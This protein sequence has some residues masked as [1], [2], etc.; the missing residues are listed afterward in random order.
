MA[1]VIACTLA[2]GGCA[3][4]RGPRIDPTGER[5]FTA[6]DPG[7]GPFKPV[8]GSPK[9]WDTVEL[10][11]VPRSTIAPVGSEVVL[12]AGV[13][14]PDGYLRTNERIEW[15]ISPG[16]VGE[17]VDYDRG[18]F[19]DIFH[20][21]WPRPHK[22]SGTFVVGSTSRRFLRLTRGTPTPNDD[23]T[24]LRGQTWVSVTS[25]VEGTSYITAYSPDVF[26]WEQRK[27]TAIV[28][29]VDAQWRL[30]PPAINPAGS[31]HVFTTM[32]MRQSDQAPCAGWRVQYSIVDGPPAGFAPSGAASV[33]VETNAQGQASAEIFQ[34]QPASGTN[35]IAI[36]IIRPAPAGGAAGTRLVVGGGFTSKTWTAPGLA[37]RKS[38]PAT[39]AVGTTLAYRIEVS[40]PGDM[41]NDGVTLTDEV[42]DET[43][44][45]SSNPPGQLTGRRVQWQMG[46]LGPG[47]RRVIE[48]LL[49]AER[50]GTITT[51]AEAAAANGLRAKD[52]A[53]TTISLAVPP[54]V[55]PGGTCVGPAGAAPPLEVRISGPDRAYVG[56]VVRF[57]IQITN[58][59]ATTATGIVVK[60]R[61][62]P[63]LAHE[64]LRSPIKK[65]LNEDLPAGQSREVFVEFRAVLPGRQ[66]QTVEITG[67]GGNV[68]RAEHCV[69]VMERPGAA[70]PA[71]PSPAPTP[72]STTPGTTV[73]TP[74]PGATPT[75]APT[76]RISVKLTGP[77]SA[78]TG[79][80]VDF[81]IEL[82]NDGTQPLT[83]LK[84]VADFDP[85]LEPKGASEAVAGYEGDAVYW[86]LASLSAAQKKTIQ[87][88]CACLKE[89]AKACIRV[90]VT[91]AGAKPAQEERC[92]PI[93]A[94]AAAAPTTGLSVTISALHEPVAVGKELTYVVQVT[95]GGKTE[96]SQVELQVLLPDEM[97]PALLGM[98]GPTPVN[99]QGKTVKFQPVERLRP[100]E[101]LA[102][103][104]RV[105]AKTAGEVRVKAELTSRNQRQPVLAEARTTIVPGR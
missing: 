51:C 75:P 77:S 103:R 14:G 55:A 12:L 4:W 92:L 2:A 53:T 86:T 64:T 65:A 76:G 26:G 33:E 58:R 41:P 68:A 23:V 24:V 105:Q 61:F 59:G 48:V 22:P 38:G 98:H 84:V 8:P 100:G 1:I 39:G 35:R 43:S 62:D 36:Q 104:V 97:I 85:A 57:Q 82:A 96:E 18:T 44:Y 17:F 88:R 87:V 81:F 102:Y 31:R 90:K 101:T 80:E 89:A 83:N 78:S 94:P 72:P 3:E 6:S 21:T 28:H 25:P 32:V 10:L 95:N 66:C 69:T 56:D 93:R 50:Q 52:C 67:N 34:Q 15:S 71:A 70:P 37:V 46:R 19:W 27:Q 42:P 49:R 16:S 9:P 11:L 7:V 73:P 29:W 79:Q 63:G 54:G 99:V 13:A 40:N 45:M 47:E 20:G 74:T 60:D 5:L 91:A 30:P